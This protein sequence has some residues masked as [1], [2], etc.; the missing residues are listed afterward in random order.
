MNRIILHPPEVRGQR[1]SF[2]WDVEPASALYRKPWFM[3]RFPDFIDLGRV[4][5][6]LWTRIALICLHPHWALL[7]PCRVELPFRLQAGE[8]EFWSRLIDAAVTTLEAYR[9]G[10][11]VSR[12]VEI[13][14]SGAPLPRF[15]PLAE[16]GRCAT[17]FSGGK[18]SLLQTGLLAE[19]THR[20][21]LVTTT[22]PQP[23]KQDHD[24]ARRRHILREIANRRDITL[25]DVESDYRANLDN[26]F[27]RTL[28]HVV[29]TN[30]L[31]DALLYFASL[32]ASSVALG[33]T[34]LF[35][36]SEAEVQENIELNGAVVQHPHFM[37]S[38]VTQRALDALLSPL[39]LRYGS[40][41][42]PLYS[43]QVQELLWTR[44]RDLRDLQYSCWRV[45]GDEAV[46]SRCRQCL[47]IAFCALAL[48]D[49][50]TLIGVNMAKLLIAMRGWAPKQ[51]PISECPVM[52]NKIVSARNTTHVARHIAATTPADVLRAIACGSTARLLSPWTWLAMAS[53]RRLRRRAVKHCPG[54]PPGW[55][56]GFLPLLDPL[57][58]S[59][60]GAIYAEYFRPEDEACYAGVLSRSD[61]LASW[62]IEPLE[63]SDFRYVEAKEA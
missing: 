39:G 7:R 58:R 57:V 43:C 51:V 40:L 29:W 5:E 1:V 22:S 8:A 36:A 38:V 34:H 16:S 14:E 63:V 60:V 46:C 32:L 26:D 10:T 13:R 17:S 24:T 3:L 30:E 48:G 49:D 62:I 55:R 47:K 41:T 56:T 27:P 61:A 37:Y 21:V 31:T 33:V 45:Q 53:Y 9:G 59:R 20:P 15:R 54:D 19:L 2:A 11:D 52:P 18:D 23:P 42:S 12:Q 25:V 6:A 50:P 28:G 4:P 44:Y 35:L